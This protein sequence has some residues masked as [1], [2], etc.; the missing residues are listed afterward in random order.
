MTDSNH[1][2][3]PVEVEEAKANAAAAAKNEDKTSGGDNNTG[4]GKPN[5]GGIGFRNNIVVPPNCPAGQKVTSDGKC[6]D[7]MP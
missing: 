5:V 3:F 4:K 6:H 1:K 7:Y 2:A